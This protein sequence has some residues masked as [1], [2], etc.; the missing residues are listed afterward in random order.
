MRNQILL[1]L[2]L[3][4]LFNACQNQTTKEPAPVSADEL[5]LRW[6]HLGN[7]PEGY[8]ARFVL[9]NEGDH[10]FPAEGWTLYFNQIGGSLSDEV[11]PDAARVSRVSGYLLQLQPAADMQP[12]APGD[13]ISFTYGGGGSIIKEAT[14]PDGPYIVYEGQEPQVIN[15][16]R[17]APFT[18]PDQI[19][20]GAGDQVPIPTPQQVYADNAQLTKLDAATL[21]PIVPTPVSYTKT[22]GSTAIDAQTTIYFQNGLK[23]EAGFLAS[24]LQD[25]LGI[26]VSTRGGESSGANSIALRRGEVQVDGQTH[27]GGSEAYTLNIGENQ[28]MVIIGADDAGVFYGIQTLLG[29]IPPGTYANPQTPVEIQGAAIADVPRFGYRGMHLDV[30]R[31]FHSKESV[32]K[33]LDLMAFY[34]LNKFHFHLTDDEGWRLEIPDLPELTE[35][36]ARRGHTLDEEDY[37]LSAYGSGPDPDA[38][39]S[40]GNGYYSREDYIEILEHATARHIEVIPEIDMPGHARAAILAMKAR[41]RRLQNEGRTQEAMDYI[42]HD[43][44]DSSEYMSVQNYDDNVICVCQESTYRFLST[45]VRNILGMYKDAAAP[46]SAL[47][48]G[49]DEVPAGVWEDSPK[50]RELIEQNPEIENVVD[51]NYYFVRRFDEILD[52]YDLKTAGWEEIALE[53]VQTDQGMRYEPHPE[54]VDDDFIPYVWNNLG[55]NLDLANRLANA[56]Y[57]VVLCNVT[58]F[59]FDLAYNKD[60]QEPGLTWGGFIDTR[61]PFEFTPEDIFR[62]TYQDPMGNPYNPAQLYEQ[63]ETM[64]PAGRRNILGLQGEL[65][66]ETIK[67]QEMLEYYAFPKILGLSERA[68]APQPEWA[69]IDDAEERM[70]ALDEDWNRFANRLGHYELPRLDE[71]FDGVGYR[72]PPPGAVIENGQLKANTAFPGLTI[73]YTTDGLEPTAGSP[74]YEGPVEVSGTVKLATFATDDRKSRTVTVTANMQG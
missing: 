5:E 22:D 24:R 71:L 45:V 17:I 23:E 54:F 67:G 3:P 37:L 47:H 18:R 7:T 40:Y 26:Q 49:G 8:Q 68:W 33:L 70:A 21:T 32:L 9:T 20:R 39:E 31:N 16:F 57:P 64:S 15:D 34:K 44:Q 74:L 38:T 28:G 14:A 25:I 53:R 52:R 62:S 43:P 66:S 2:A 69:R 63:F 56:G 58:N 41:M 19:N 50:C 35:V 11:Q 12:V 27:E 60:P 55:G 46:L 4:L 48:I 10:P 59:Y 73:R 42:L 36:G 13:S 1:L 51:L 65:W 6:E 29:L 30:S 72:L 61:K